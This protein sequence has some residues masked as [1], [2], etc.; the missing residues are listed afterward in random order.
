MHRFR[1]LGI[2]DAA[3]HCELCGTFCPARRVAVELVDVDGATTG[4]VQYWGV[5]CAAEARSGRRDS[6]I[7][8]QLRQ[9]AE[10]AGEY[11]AAGRPHA[12]RRSRPAVRRQS[13]RE[14]AA[15]AA[16]AFAESQ[17]VWNRTASPVPAEHVTETGIDAAAYRYRK[18]GRPTAGAYFMADDDGRLAVI[19]GTD[20]A[21]VELFT[22]HGFRPHAAGQLASWPDAGTAAGYAAAV[23]SG[24]A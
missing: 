6:T 20:A 8:R 24:A 4:D 17:I 13:R 23:R 19:D 9:E 14:A 2:T 3:G 18:T 1:V 12:G 7:A 11:D 16:R 10:H 15:A 21:D 5:V 22:R